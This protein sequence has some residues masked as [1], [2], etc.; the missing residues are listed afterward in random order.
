M[1]PV[2]ATQYVTDESARLTSKLASVNDAYN[3]QMRNA[4]LNDSYRKRYAK[5]IEVVTILIL[6]TVAYL[7]ISYFQSM[8]P[9]LPS[10]V[11]DA[12]S[13][14]IVSLVMLYLLFA[15]FELFTRSN[16]NYDEIALPPQDISGITVNNASVGNAITGPA[17][18]ANNGLVDTCAEA[19]CCSTGTYWDTTASK[20]VA[21]S[22]APSAFS[23]LSDAYE[24][25]QIAAPMTGKLPVVDYNSIG[26][27]ASAEAVVASTSISFSNV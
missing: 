17:R 19:S 3:A 25:K 22:R 24:Y 11:F 15:A 18:T 16:M 9:D 20:C 1:P 10:I 2:D 23:T 27:S 12:L 7:G 8:F 26:S 14:I 4:T 21:G 6:A 13:I 5:Y